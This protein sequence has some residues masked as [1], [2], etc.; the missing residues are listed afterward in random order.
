MRFMIPAAINKRKTVLEQ[1]HC[2]NWM[3]MILRAYLDALCAVC[4][5]FACCGR[6]SQENLPGLPSPDLLLPVH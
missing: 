6:D 1:N 3:Q 2:I 5:N 4:E